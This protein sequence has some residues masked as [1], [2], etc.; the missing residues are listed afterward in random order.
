MIAIE[1]PQ[2]VAVVLDLVSVVSIVVE[3]ETPDIGA[4]VFDHGAKL[5]LGK[6][7]VAGEYDPPHRELGA[8]LDLEDEID[9]GDIAAGF[10]LDDLRHDLRVEIAAVLV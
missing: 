3:E 9:R 4:A 1:L 8:L 7:L 6:R 2:Q 5:G 10:R